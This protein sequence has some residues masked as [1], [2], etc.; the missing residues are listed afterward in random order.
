MRFGFFRSFTYL[1]SLF[2]H[3]PYADLILSPPGVIRR[4]EGP[5]EIV[6]I[7][8]RYSDRDRSGVR[9]RG[10]FT[11]YGPSVSPEGDN[12]VSITNRT[13]KSVLTISGLRERDNG[14]YHC[15]Y[16]SEHAHTAII[17]HGE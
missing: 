8:C 13:H 14:S 10:V 2:H 1:T 16:A 15:T 5:G 3:L 12:R 17:V 9:V 4:S 7:T 11:W 6:R